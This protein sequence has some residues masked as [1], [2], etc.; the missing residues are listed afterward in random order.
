ML[1]AEVDLLNRFFNFLMR[2]PSPEEIMSLRA[3]EEENL[4]FEH[5]SAKNATGNISFDEKLELEYFLKAEHLIRMA[6]IKAFSEQN[7]QEN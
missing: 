7:N 5:L 3:S 6:K 4:R 1:V 2:N